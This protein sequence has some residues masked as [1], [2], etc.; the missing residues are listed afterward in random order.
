MFEYE[1]HYVKFDSYPTLCIHYFLHK[2]KLF[3]ILQLRH[4]TRHLILQNLQLM[5]SRRLEIII[6]SIHI[7]WIGEG[8]EASFTNINIKAGTNGFLSSIVTAAASL[9]GD[10]CDQS[11]FIDCGDW[12]TIF[13]AKTGGK[14]N[15]KRLD[16]RKSKQHF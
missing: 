13:R 14:K 8:Y 6:K 12:R 15:Q 11:A 9:L 7:A 4:Q 2:D 1:V 16:T 10:C 5:N 3:L